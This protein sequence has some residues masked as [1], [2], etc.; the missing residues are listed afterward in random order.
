MNRRFQNSGVLCVLNFMGE[1]REAQQCDREWSPTDTSPGI[2]RS[3][4]R[5]RPACRSQGA[6]AVLS[7]YCLIEKCNHVET[8]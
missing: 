5:N 6:I 1:G 2:L 4:R 3:Y 8:K 7:R